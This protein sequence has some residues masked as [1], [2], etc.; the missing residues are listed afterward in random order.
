[1]TT[2]YHFYR[3]GSIPG[4]PGIFAGVVVT[5]NEATN[6]IIEI[7]PLHQAGPAPASPSSSISPEALSSSDPSDTL[8]DHIEDKEP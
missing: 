1:M 4:I 3:A 6:E 5:V 2:K 7:A 8:E